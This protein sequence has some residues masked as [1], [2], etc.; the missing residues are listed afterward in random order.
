MARKHKNAHEGA[1]DPDTMKASNEILG[2]HYSQ[3]DIDRAEE[4]ARIDTFNNR[5][6]R[7]GG[8]FGCLSAAFDNVG[9]SNNTKK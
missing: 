7:Q 3:E 1:G 5:K 4:K 2:G 8:S 6:S 9:N